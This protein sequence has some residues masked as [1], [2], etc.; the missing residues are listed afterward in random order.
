MTQSRWVMT[1]SDLVM[2]MRSMND[3][4][5]L[6]ENAATVDQLLATTF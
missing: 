3:A 5:E 1:K 4:R 2:S 6:L